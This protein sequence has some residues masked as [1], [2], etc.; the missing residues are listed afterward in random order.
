MLQCT[1]RVG[2]IEGSA[3]ASSACML[4]YTEKDHIFVTRTLITFSNVVN[5]VQFVVLFTK[6]E[7]DNVQFIVQFTM[8]EVDNVNLLFYSR[9]SIFRVNC[10]EI[11]IL[12]DG[13]THYSENCNLE[14][15]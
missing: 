6:L 15:S 10:S 3:L 5:N 1:K 12:W 9:C 7:V 13:I 2:N 4:K 14:I 8:Q 11:P